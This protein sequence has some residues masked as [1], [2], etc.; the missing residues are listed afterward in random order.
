MPLDQV[1]LA[2]ALFGVAVVVASAAYI[3]GKTALY[4]GAAVLE[5]AKRD[6]RK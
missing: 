2:F 3:I 6:L 4:I 1:T 5:K